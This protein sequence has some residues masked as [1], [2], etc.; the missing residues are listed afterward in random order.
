MDQRDRGQ[1]QNTLRREK[2][3]RELETRVLEEL[4][5]PKNP[6]IPWMNQEIANGCLEGTF[7]VVLESWERMGVKE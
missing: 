1:G 3:E 7:T 6:K 5:P 2:T 4:N